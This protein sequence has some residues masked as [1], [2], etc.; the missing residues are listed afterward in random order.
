MHETDI[1]ILAEYCVGLP[2]RVVIVRVDGSQLSRITGR[3]A[4]LVVS[5]GKFRTGVCI[6]RVS[7][8]TIFLVY[9]G[10]VSTTFLLS[11]EHAMT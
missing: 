5:N 11:S 6:S 1:H 8:T 10:K 3:F 9:H 7:F 4:G 2:E